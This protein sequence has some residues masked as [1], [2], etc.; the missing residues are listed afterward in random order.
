MPRVERRNNEGIDNMLKRFRR[1]C[2]D[3]GIQ[4]EIRKREFYVPPS[5]KR[6]VKRLNHQK[7]SRFQN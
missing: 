5:E 6:K 4:N 7:L 1:Q 3:A 2:Q